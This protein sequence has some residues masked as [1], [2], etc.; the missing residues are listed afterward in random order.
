MNTRSRVF[1]AALSLAGCVQLATAQSKGREHHPS[2]IV[3][4]G[5]ADVK[6]LKD[7]DGTVIYNVRATYPAPQLID[8]IKKQ[9]TEQGWQPMKFDLMNPDIPSSYF[10]GWGEVI[11]RNDELVKR[12][13]GDWRKQGG[14]A[15]R[16]SFTYRFPPDRI[17]VFVRNDKVEVT[18]IYMTA[19]TVTALLGRLGLPPSRR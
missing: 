1:A 16:Y 6:F 15:V 19:P 13:G 17:G 18:A 14:A 4:E 2:L 9:L 8:A 11:G 7:Y 3:V 12:W 10:D 5:A